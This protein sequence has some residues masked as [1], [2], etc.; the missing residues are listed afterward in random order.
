MS[1]SP[2]YVSKF[3]ILL[4]VRLGVNKMCET[5]RPVCKKMFYPTPMWEKSSVSLMFPRQGT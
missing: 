3:V 4:E 5:L 2:K 1:W